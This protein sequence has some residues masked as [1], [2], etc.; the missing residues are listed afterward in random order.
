MA[1]IVVLLRNADSAATGIIIRA[2]PVTSLRER[3][4]IRP[5]SAS[6]AP[7]SRRA[8]ER[9]S[10]APTVAIDW[11]EKPA[12]VSVGVST[13]A[14]ASVKRPPMSTTSGEVTSRAIAMIVAASTASVN[15]PCQ[16]MVRLVYRERWA[17]ATSSPDWAWG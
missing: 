6:T 11:F 2:R 7:V 15:Q 8:A 17:A 3:P 9:T 16:S 1:T 13:P 14:A 12:K 4:K 10:S 5:K